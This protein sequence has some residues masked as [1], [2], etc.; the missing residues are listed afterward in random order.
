MLESVDYSNYL[1][2][3]ECTFNVGSWSSPHNST[4]CT[5]TLTYHH[6][7][8]FFSIIIYLFLNH[9]YLNDGDTITENGCSPF[10]TNAVTALWHS[11]VFSLVIFP[12][13]AKENDVSRLAVPG[14]TGGIIGGA[15]EV[16]ALAV[17]D[18][19]RR[20]QDIKHGTSF[21]IDA[22][23]RFEVQP[24]LQLI[25]VPHL[26][27]FA[28]SLPFT[29]WSHTFDYLPRPILPWLVAAMSLQTYS[30]CLQ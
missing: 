20:P 22:V 30:R 16:L 15:C 1:W 14:Y 26:L 24:A 7:I 10:T 9:A 12:V 25:N 2:R 8:F 3:E 13:I 23:A 17:G 4:G 5:S 18:R 19:A 21:Q 11:S 29:K 6:Q 27:H 28:L